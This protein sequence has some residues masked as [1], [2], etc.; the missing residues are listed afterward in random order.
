M[1]SKMILSVEVDIWVYQIVQ[2]YLL[3]CV[4]SVTPYRQGV[5]WVPLGVIV[6]GYPALD[7]DDNDKPCDGIVIG[8]VNSPW[9]MSQGATLAVSRVSVINIKCQILRTP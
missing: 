5:D 1:V 4:G 6:I 2:F 7:S 9:W 3:G 8:E